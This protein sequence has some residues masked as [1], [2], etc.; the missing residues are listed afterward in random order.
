MPPPRPLGS[1]QPL[2]NPR[3][4]VAPDD[5]I[6]VGGGPGKALGQRV[7]VYAQCQRAAVGVAELGGD[8]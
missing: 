4:L 8:V 3:S 5:P 7:D 1:L 2:C 6:Q